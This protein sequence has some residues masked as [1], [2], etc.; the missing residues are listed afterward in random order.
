MTASTCSGGSFTPEPETQSCDPKFLV[1][2]QLLLYC[3]DWRIPS[4]IAGVDEAP[5][6]IRKLVTVPIS[7]RGES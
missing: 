6:Y 5:T 7:W 1:D 4:R 2:F 3:E